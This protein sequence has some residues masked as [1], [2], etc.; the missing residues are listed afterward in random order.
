MELKISQELASV[1]RP[2]GTT[3]IEFFFFLR[4][5]IF[6]KL[7]KAPVLTE[8]VSVKMCCNLMV[9]QAYGVENGLL[10]KFSKLVKSVKCLK[11]IFM[12]YMIHQQ[13][14]W[15]NYLNLSCY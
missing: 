4:E 2:H 3:P 6:K 5:K 1:D 15:G 12:H 11:S 14:F 13:V 10:G 7:E 9:V 8:V